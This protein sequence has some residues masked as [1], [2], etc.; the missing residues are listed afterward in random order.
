MV[1]D[2]ATETQKN[3]EE[4]SDPAV[5]LAGKMTLSVISLDSNEDEDQKKENTAEIVGV[6]GV[7]E[8]DESKY[9]TVSNATAAEKDISEVSLFFQLRINL[10]NV[11]IFRNKIQMKMKLMDKRWKKYKMKRH[12]F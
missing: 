5:V 3:E 6:N 7:D 12:Q 2:S 1:A 8:I 9:T 4:N 11:Y 10:L